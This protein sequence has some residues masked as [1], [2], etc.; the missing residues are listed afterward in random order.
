ME[1]PNKKDYKPKEINCAED[2]VAWEMA[3]SNKLEM[4]CKHLE[5]KLKNHGVSHHVITC[6]KCGSYDLKQLDK[7]MDECNKCGNIQYV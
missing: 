1:K 6:N 4:Y 5:S 7:A 2:L 3:Y